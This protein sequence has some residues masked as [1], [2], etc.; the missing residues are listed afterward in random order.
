MSKWKPATVVKESRAR[1]PSHKRSFV[2]AGEARGAADPP[3]GSQ[4]E[5]DGI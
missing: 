3:P 5:L 4:R 2:V 1:S